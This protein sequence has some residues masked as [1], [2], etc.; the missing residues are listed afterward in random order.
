[1]R[2][3]RHGGD[4]HVGARLGGHDEDVAQIAGIGAAQMVWLNPVISVSA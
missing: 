4:G 3:R 1:V 2:E